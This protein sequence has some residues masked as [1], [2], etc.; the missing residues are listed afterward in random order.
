MTTISL[1][2]DEK[3]SNA[4]KFIEFIKTLNYITLDE[5]MSD[6]DREDEG[7]YK[8]M[9]QADRTKKVSREKVMTKLLK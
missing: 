9:Q 6:E 5:K 1:K 2:F 3:N 8:L 7:L 4:K